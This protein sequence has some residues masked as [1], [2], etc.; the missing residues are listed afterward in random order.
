MN[1]HVDIDVDPRYHPFW[2]LVSQMVFGVH[3]LAKGLAKSDVEVM[4]ILQSHVDEVDG[5][6][7][8]TT[9]DFL[10]IHLDVRTRIQYLSLPLDNLD[11]F[12][13]MLGDRNFR[14]S[15]V[16]YNDQIEHAVE[17]FTSAI[18]DSLKDLRKGK[19][20]MGAL[21]HY[22]RQLADEG[23]FQSYSLKAFYQTMMDNLEGWITTLSKLRRRGAALHKALGQLAF[24]VT[25]MQ[26]R[27]GVA[28]RRDARSF[29]KMVNK[30][31]GRTRSVKEKLF[32]RSS[33]VRSS[34]PVSDKPLPRDPFLKPKT[35]RPASRKPEDAPPTT[36]DDD[37]AAAAYANTAKRET[38]HPM[39]MNRTRS[40]SALV[41]GADLANKTEATT[42][43]RTPGRLSRK[44]SKPFLPKRSVSEKVNTPPKRPSTAPARTLKSRTASIE[45]LKAM[46]TYGRP[47]TQQAVVKSPTRP[48]QHASS[49][50]ADSSESMKDQ[51]SQYLKTDRVVEAWDNI[52][53]KTGCCGKNIAKTKEWP[54][55]IFRAKSSDNLR[56]RPQNG[57]FAQ[58]DFERQMSWLQE[59]EFLNTYSFKQ[60]PEASPR[61]HVLSVQMTLDED[62]TVARE[63]EEAPDAGDTGSIITALP[64][65]PPPTPA[66]IP[67]VSEVD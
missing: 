33:T 17:R 45:Q 26:R 58:R 28:S 10:I 11:V 54:S 48:R 53:T 60:R 59:P 2:K 38:P 15:L 50:H 22:L 67:S 37:A 21:W 20:A 44:L 23:C 65:V 51:I 56:G 32:A 4:K 35:S 16:A 8:R 47:S 42:P 39:V 41:G 43:P 12:D 62:L 18:T 30:S 57:G 40:C 25:E 36:K 13:E 3:L 61:I 27:V 55:S 46:W 52:T 24:A 63:G 7:Q 66:S 6:L 1:D 49:Q 19:E 31:P 34:R 64:A 14:L 29:I 5:F 9:E